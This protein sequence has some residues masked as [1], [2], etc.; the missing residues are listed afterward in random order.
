MIQVWPPR[1]ALCPQSQRT[2]LSTTGL[3]AASTK[4]SSSSSTSQPFR[5]LGTTEAGAVAG[6]PMTMSLRFSQVRMIAPR[7]RSMNPALERIVS[8]G[9]KVMP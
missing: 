4:A 2:R 6:S 1:I 7:R 9:T 3:I 5:V 8:G